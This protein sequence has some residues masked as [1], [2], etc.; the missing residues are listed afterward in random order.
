M[1]LMQLCFSNDLVNDAFRD[2]LRKIFK[3]Q[4]GL[5]ASVP[6]C[7]SAHSEAA[8]LCPGCARS[9]PRATQQLS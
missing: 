8:A 1:K 7:H 2:L 6:T 4:A 3:P 9:C 5:Q